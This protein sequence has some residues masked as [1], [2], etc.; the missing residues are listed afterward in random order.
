MKKTTLFLAFLMLMSVQMVY[1]QQKTRRTTQKTAKSP[2]SK[3]KV[4]KVGNVS[5][6]MVYVE[7]GDCVLGRTSDQGEL[8]GSGYEDTPRLCNISSFYIGQTVVSQEL[9]TAVMGDNPSKIKGDKLPVDNVSW[10]DCMVFITHL[11]GITDANFRMPTEWEWEYAARGGQKS[12]YFKFAG[13]NNSEEV[14]C[15]VNDPIGSKK[16]NELGIYGMHG[17]PFEWCRNWYWGVNQGG[18]DPQGPSVDRGEGRA[19][20]SG[21]GLI[22]QRNHFKPQWGVAG[23]RLARSVK[24]TIIVEE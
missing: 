18:Q 21:P 1:G 16:P 3:N 11:N 15:T 9:W 23:L 6:T 8:R 20:R 4:Y 12:Q 2:Q 10:D 7:G 14:L 19:V 5:F 17:A 22:C 13:S 24:R